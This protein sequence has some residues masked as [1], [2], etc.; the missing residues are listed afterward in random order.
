M[1]E[2][3]GGI[4][5]RP[6]RGR[7]QRIPAMDGDVKKRLGRVR[8]QIHDPTLSVL[9]ILLAFL[10]FV[11]VPL[12]AVGVISAQGN[13]FAIVLLLASCVLVQSKR[14]MAILVIVL[15]VGLAAAAVLLRLKL[16]SN[17][18]LFLEAGATLAM[19]VLLIFVIAGAVFAPG[20]ITYHRVNGAVLLYLTIGLTFV[21]LFTFVGLAAPNAFKGLS[22]EN[23]PEVASNLI[24]F[25]FVTLTTIGYGDI[26]PVHPAARSLCNLEAIIGQLYPATLLARLV[27]L[28]LE[29]RRK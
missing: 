5:Q 26:T 23:S 8:D 3:D 9:T 19:N 2:Q 4:A 28:E 22:I 14:L 1:V 15:A 24:Y 16:P 20:R 17:L 27:T 13:G 11:I 10:I 7:G 21:A 6:R 18:D 25:S 29:D 12:H